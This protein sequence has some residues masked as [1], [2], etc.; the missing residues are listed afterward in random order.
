MGVEL[1]WFGDIDTFLGYEKNEF[2]RTIEAWENILHP[3]D[4]EWVLGFH[5]VMVC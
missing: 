4:K 2:P 1:K 3:D 5:F